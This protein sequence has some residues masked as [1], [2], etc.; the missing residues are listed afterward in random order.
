MTYAWHHLK[1]SDRLH[2][3]FAVTIPSTL[4]DFHCFVVLY[5][6]V[7]RAKAAGLRGLCSAQQDGSRV[8]I[9][10]HALLG[11]VA[12]DRG[13]IFLV[14]ERFRAPFRIPRGLVLDV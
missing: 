5:H 6:C 2:T 9:C 14:W 8:A 10:S 12:S 1:G 7:V 13:A 11:C 3:F 4:H